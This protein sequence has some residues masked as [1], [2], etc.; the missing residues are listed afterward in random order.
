MRMVPALRP[1]RPAGLAL[2]ALLVLAPLLSAA[3]SA[4]SQVVVGECRLPVAAVASGG[5]GVIGYVHVRVVYPGTGKVYL[6]TSPATEI[7]TQGAARLAAFAAALAA[8]ADFTR[9]DYFFD[10]ESPSVIVGGPS[11]GLPMAL[12]TLAALEGLDCGSARFVATGMMLPDGSVGPVG[13]LKEKLQA[14]AE[15][16]ARLF[17]VPRG[18]LV[19]RDYERVAERLGPLVIV[20]TVPVEVDLRELGKELGVEVVEA[21]TIWD[22]ASEAF[23]LQAKRPQAP[24][25]HLEAPGLDQ[26]YQGLAGSYEEL[27]R[28]LQGAPQWLSQLVEAATQL[29]GEAS[30]AAGEGLYLPAIRLEAEALALLQAASWLSAAAESGDWS[31][32]GQVEE[33]RAAISGVELGGDESDALAAVLLWRAGASLSKALEGLGEGYEVPRAPGLGVN[34]EP[35][36]DLARALWLARAAEAVAGLDWPAMS[37]AGERLRALLGLASD[38]V[39]YSLALAGETREAGDAAGMLRAASASGNPVEAAGLA[40]A[41][42]G[43]ALG[44]VTARYGIDPSA[45]ASLAAETGGP[46]AAALLQLYEWATARGDPVAAGEAAYAALMLAWLGKS[47][48]AAPAE[49]GSATPAGSAATPQQPTTTTATE[50][51]TTPTGGAATGA[52]G[53]EGEGAGAGLTV[54]AA[55]VVAVASALAGAALASRLLRLG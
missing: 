21:A 53:L 31:L 48:P 5:G 39:A 29:H 44:A 10:L 35:V 42:A 3:A 4:E 40:A 14:A 43:L 55:L 36:V 45:A 19:Y 16:G 49:A 9:Y 41:A 20:R 18:Q 37:I 26:V 34:A 17:I 50:T 2:L 13:G 32:K 30:T 27:S 52:G 51:T 12:A 54:I 33:A 1:L 47:Y 25:G 7:D 24:G 22:A 38:A 46:A 23:G 6:S 8:G 15:W 11:A 28:Q